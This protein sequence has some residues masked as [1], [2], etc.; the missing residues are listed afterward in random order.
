MQPSQSQ[1]SDRVRGDQ[2]RRRGLGGAAVHCIESLLN[3]KSCQQN[4]A[5]Q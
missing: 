4:R 3:A 2:D 5:S 1:P